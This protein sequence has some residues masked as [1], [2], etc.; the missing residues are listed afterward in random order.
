MAR[1]AQQPRG[2]EPGTPPRVRFGYISGYSTVDNTRLEALAAIPKEKGGLT[3]REFRVLQWYVGATPGPDQPVM[4]TTAQIA[5][6]LG[7]SPDA[8]GRIVRKL[9][10]RRLLFFVEEF[11]RQRFY[12]VSPYFASQQ[13]AFEQRT[14]I[15]SYNPPDIPGLPGATRPVKGELA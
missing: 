10:K 14:T 11:G 1:P 8:L 9:V 15:K 4:K 13:E 6:R 3:D 12:K 7:T 2:N 5:E